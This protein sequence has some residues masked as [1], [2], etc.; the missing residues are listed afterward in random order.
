MVPTDRFLSRQEQRQELLQPECPVYVHCTRR[1]TERR[2]GMELLQLRLV[3]RSF[4][5]VDS[6]FF[7]VEGICGESRVCYTMKGMVM[8]DCR[9]AAG[10]V[11]GE[12]H[13]FILNKTPVDRVLITVEKVSFSDGMLWRRRA[14]WG[15]TDLRH[16]GWERCTCGMPHPVGDESCLLCGRSFLIE[17]SEPEAPQLAAEAEL[18]GAE[19]FP[20]PAEE[21][22]PCEEPIVE[23]VEEAAEEAVEETLEAATEATEE[24]AAPLPLEEQTLCE[25]AAESAPAEGTAALEAEIEAALQT[26]EEELRATAR[27]AES[28]PVIPVPAQ[29]AEE[30]RPLPAEEEKD[31][32]PKWLIILLAILGSAAAACVVAFLVFLLRQYIL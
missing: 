25:E 6:L 26:A 24:T 7:T 30:V 18:P 21:E 12:E 23:T 29:Q 5:T 2:S 3:N 31:G 13:I 28:F 4:R 8:S 10:S 15:L 1:T 27:A 9:G 32:F 22:L 20:T 16:A 14:G 17:A 19:P 11:F